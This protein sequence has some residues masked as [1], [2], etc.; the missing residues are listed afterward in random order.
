MDL[1]SVSLS[2]ALMIAQSLLPPAITVGGSFAIH[3]YMKPIFWVGLDALGGYVSARVAAN[4]GT[5]MS[6]PCDKWSKHKFVRLSCQFLL[7]RRRGRCCLLS[8]SHYR[9][10]GPML[11]FGLVDRLVS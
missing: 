8:Y 1:Y 2:A 3:L 11:I 7:S 5:H 9:L 4:E 6:S 10:L